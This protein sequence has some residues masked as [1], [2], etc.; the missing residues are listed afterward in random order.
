METIAFYFTKLID[1]FL[2]KTVDVIWQVFLLGGS[3]YGGHCHK[4]GL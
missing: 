3:T 1:R 4:F 2:E